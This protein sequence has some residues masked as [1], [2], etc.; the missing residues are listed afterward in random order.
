MDKELIYFA[1]EIFTQENTKKESQMVKVNIPGKMVK[2][3]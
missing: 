3:M 1:M 2:H